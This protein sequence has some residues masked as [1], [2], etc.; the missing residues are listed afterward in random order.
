MV[1]KIPLFTVLLFCSCWIIAQKDSLIIENSSV[2]RV[3]R[4]TKDSLG[5]YSVAFTNKQSA[6]NY[7]N[8][9]TEEFSITI[10]DST[11]D[12]KNCRYKSHFFC[13]VKDTKSL[14]V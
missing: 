11:L 12:G 4:F 7:V 14:T 10:N 1:K 9:D 13:H 2:A 8:P 5:F 3:L 6:Q